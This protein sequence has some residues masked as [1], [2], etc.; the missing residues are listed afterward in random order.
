ESTLPLHPRTPISVRMPGRVPLAIVAVVLLAGACTATARS[1][2]RLAAGGTASVFPSS[3]PG[4]QTATPIRHVVFIIMENRSFDSM[5]GRF[6]GA[7]GT[8]VG[9]LDGHTI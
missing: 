8:T 9:K 2:P 1:A 7:D 6:P 3:S 5:F 4:G